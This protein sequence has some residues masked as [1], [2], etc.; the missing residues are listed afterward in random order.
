M[1]ML[2]VL[3]NVLERGLKTFGYVEI[4]KVH[5]CV[6]MQIECQLSTRP[7]FETNIFQCSSILFVNINRYAM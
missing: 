5:V 6:K 4:D 3:V 7:L 1:C 2:H